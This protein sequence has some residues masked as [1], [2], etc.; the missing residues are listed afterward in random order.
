MSGL[1]FFSSGN[2]QADKRYDFAMAFLASGQEPE[3]LELLSSISELAPSW[4][5]PAFII[6]K[7][8]MEA[9]RK[10]EASLAFQQALAL[11]PEDRQGAAVKLQLLDSAPLTD[12]L[13][14]CYVQ[15]LFDEYAPRFDQHLVGTLGYNVPDILYESACALRPLGSFLRILDLGCGTGLAAEKFK[16]PTRWIEGVDLSPGM[17]AEA[18][19]KGIYQHLHQGDLQDYLVQSEGHFDLVLASD[20][21]NYC[22]ALDGVFT[23]A[24][25]RLLEDGIFA[26][27]VQI[28]ADGDADFQLGEDHRFSHKPEYIARLLLG[29]G[30]T[31]LSSKNH[32]LRRD[33]G[34]DVN[35]LV[36]LAGKT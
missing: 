26:F 36:V 3:A 19:K 22:G 11:D 35:G 5:V 20:V 34:Q 18:R 28:L 32:V 31:I 4:P 7:I 12:G 6:G 17:L 15:S 30:Y 9:G 13:P 29:A 24:R 10:D 8:H 25:P 16:A 23:A 2:L 21:L 27:C 14:A 1:T 33:G